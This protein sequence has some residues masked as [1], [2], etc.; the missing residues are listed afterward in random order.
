MPVETNVTPGETHNEHSAPKDIVDAE[1]NAI[2]PDDT[3]TGDEGGQ[4]IESLTKALNDT[5]A[6]LT[7]LQQG[8]KPEDDKDAEDKSKDE[9]DEDKT[10]DEPEDKV[11]EEAIKAGVDFPALSTEYETTGELSEKTYA[12]LETKGF[13]KQVVD[14]YIAGQVARNDVQTK[15]LGEI[16]GGQENIPT[17]MEW[18]G[19]H[20]TAEEIKA[21]NTAASGTQAQAKLA[22]QGVYAQY[23]EAEGSA[24]NLVKGQNVNNASSDVFKS[25]HAMTKAMED[26]RYW[27]DPDYRNDVTAKAERSYKAGTI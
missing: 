1:G 16:V 8:D 6:E 20:L 9:A 4:T 22:L 12:D 23:V 2:V 15:A 17:V 24:P 13:P 27:T 10:S 21:Y 18:A 7:K 25:S 11:K 14:D 5:K 19:E 3:N 26:K